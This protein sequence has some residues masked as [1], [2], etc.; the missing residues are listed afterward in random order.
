MQLQTTSLKFKITLPFLFLLLASNVLLAQEISLDAVSWNT[1]TVANGLVWKQ[2]HTTVFNAPQNINILEINLNKRELTVVYDPTKNQPTSELASKS[3]A[4]AAINAGFF[5]IKNGGAVGY[6]KIDGKLPSTDSTKWKKSEILNG[7]LFIM[8]NGKVDVSKIGNYE[9]YTSNPKMDDVLVTGCL[10]MEN[11]ENAILPENA[12]SNNRHPRT[13]LGIV[14]KHKVLL[15]TVDGRAEE[16]AGMSLPELTALLNSLGCKEAINLDGGGSTTM[17]VSSASSGVVNKPSDNKKF[18][19][20]GE[21][22]V[23]NILV[24]R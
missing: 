10:L 6:L 18:D 19:H 12:F 8:K 1:K 15:I 13:C 16:A 23:A 9:S 2:A 7:A 21:R 24:V 5:D 3:N 4:L 20:Q 14:N 22:S 11:G 17:W